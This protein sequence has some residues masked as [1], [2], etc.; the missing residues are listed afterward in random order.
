MG[1][2]HDLRVST[3]DVID[4]LNFYDDTGNKPLREIVTVKVTYHVPNTLFGSKGQKKEKVIVFA[5]QPKD[6]KEMKWQDTHTFERLFSK[7][8][9]NNSDNVNMF[10]I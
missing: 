4:G 3:S 9:I 5:V 8:T 10:L 1:R 6:I 7:L 2:L